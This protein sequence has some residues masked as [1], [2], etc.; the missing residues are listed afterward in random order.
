MILRRKDGKPFSTEASLIGTIIKKKMNLADYEIVKE[1]NGY[2]ARSAET[3]EEPESR[4]ISE[5]R[6]VKPI[7]TRHVLRY[8]NRPGYRRRLVN[9]ENDRVEMLREAGYEIVSGKMTGTST[10]GVDASQLGSAVVRP[11]GGGVKGV[12]MEIPEDLYK[13]YQ[14]AKEAH[15]KKIDDSMRRNIKGQTSSGDYGS[16]KISNV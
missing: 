6:P 2:I 10:R 1:G 8:P 5:R 14:D 15:L 11:V 9:D 4:T 16:V 7:S 12:L 13:E 3:A